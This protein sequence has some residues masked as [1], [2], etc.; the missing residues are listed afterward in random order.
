MQLEF[1]DDKLL[2]HLNE[3]C[4]D[5]L[6]ELIISRT[7]NESIGDVRAFKKP[8]S[9]VEV[10]EFNNSKLNEQLKDIYEWF[11]LIRSLKFLNQ[12]KLTDCEYLMMPFPRLEQL[13]I[14]FKALASHR[15]DLERDLFDSDSIA[16]ALRLNSQLRSVA[17]YLIYVNHY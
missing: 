2:C 5:S 16:A 10:L 6:I 7:T 4:A 9:R 15:M 17:F 11:S 3:Y 12:T 8:F 13:T 1:D 14:D